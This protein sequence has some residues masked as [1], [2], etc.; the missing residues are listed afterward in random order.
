[1]PPFWIKVLLLTK[2]GK[3][4][5]PEVITIADPHKPLLHTSVCQQLG[6]KFKMVPTTVTNHY[7]LLRQVGSDL[8]NPEGEPVTSK[9]TFVS[10]RLNPGASFFLCHKSLIGMLVTY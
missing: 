10:L 6:V 7:M 8:K 5:S 9:D 4:H 1:M 3:K 2:D